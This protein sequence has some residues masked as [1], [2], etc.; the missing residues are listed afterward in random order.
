MNQS[1]VDF[2]TNLNFESKLNCVI[3]AVYSLARERKNTAPKREDLGTRI[4]F[5]RNF[6]S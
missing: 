3:I 2:G 5:A 4:Y 6:T 1:H